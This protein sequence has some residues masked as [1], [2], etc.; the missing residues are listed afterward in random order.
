MHHDKQA[1][2]DFDARGLGIQLK[3]N[4]YKCKHCGKIVKRQ[5]SKQWVK[6]YCEQTGKNVHLIKIKP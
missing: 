4:E 1:M 2:Y 5:T 3:E 6:S